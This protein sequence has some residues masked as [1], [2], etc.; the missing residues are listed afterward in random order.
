MPLKHAAEHEWILGSDVRD[1]VGHSAHFPHICGIGGQLQPCQSSC[2]K[3]LQQ[4][5]TQKQPQLHIWH[6]RCVF[7]KAIDN[8]MPAV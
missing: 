7:V 8:A 2:Q 5:L 4:Q 6:S 3:R 1:S